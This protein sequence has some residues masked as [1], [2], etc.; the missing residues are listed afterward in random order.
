MNS[1][2]IKFRVWDKNK[3]KLIYNTNE[4]FLTIDGRPHF[5]TGDNCLIQGKFWDYEN[6]VLQQFTGL[7]DKNNKEIYE[8]DVLI[9]VDLPYKP[10]ALKVIFDGDTLQF[11]MDKINLHDC[12]LFFNLVKYGPKWEIIGNIFENPE[13]IK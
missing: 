12:N 3:K 2:E 7:K 6:L 4:I 11:R 5:W 10:N 9:D 8:G 1:R 13:L